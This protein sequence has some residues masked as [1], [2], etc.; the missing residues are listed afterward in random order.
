MNNSVAVI[1]SCDLNLQSDIDHIIAQ[2]L[3]LSASHFDSPVSIPGQR[4][5]W[6]TKLY[7]GNVS[8]ST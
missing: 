5:L 7:W 2:A 6:W 3:K 4:D 8:L 1:K